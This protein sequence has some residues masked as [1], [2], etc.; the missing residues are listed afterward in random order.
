M[1]H[2][3][4]LDANNVV[5]RVIVVRNEVTFEQEG[6]EREE[7]GVAYCKS[8]FGEDTIWKQTSYNSN[9]RVRYAYVGG[10]YDPVKDAFINPKPYP[11]WVFN[12]TTLDWEAPVPM[13]DG[14]KDGIAYYWKEEV[15]NWVEL[16]RY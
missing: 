5:L 1:A 9:F 16:P 12:E 8:L 3:A 10:V 7:L 14:G 4:E 15:L 6:V 11:S 13:P 2:F